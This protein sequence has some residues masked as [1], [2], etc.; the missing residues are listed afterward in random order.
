MSLFQRLGSAAPEQEIYELFQ[1]PLTSRQPL[2]R[3][4]ANPSA[5]LHPRPTNTLASSQSKSDDADGPRRH[6]LAHSQPP[7][8]ACCIRPWNGTLYVPDCSA[9]AG[10]RRPR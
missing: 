8:G 10:F 2:S 4:P 6:K 9:L 3:L 5:I 7:D 1:Q